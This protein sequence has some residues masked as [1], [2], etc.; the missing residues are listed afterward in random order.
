MAMF[1]LL[2]LFYN[3]R[4]CCFGF[5]QMIDLGQLQKIRIGHDG[6]GV[7]SGQIEKRRDF[8]VTVS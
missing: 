2:L 8:V 6:A 4:F 7:G 3:L 1:F 5:V